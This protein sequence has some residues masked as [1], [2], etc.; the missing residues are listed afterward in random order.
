MS[1]F[2]VRGVPKS[3]QNDA[4][5]LSESSSNEGPPKISGT[6]PSAGKCAIRPE[7][8]VALIAF[9]LL[10][11]KLF[12]Q[13]STGISLAIYGVALGLF[14]WL[15]SKRRFVGREGI[16]GVC[17]LGVA[18]LPVIEQVQTLSIL[19]LVLGMTAFTVWTVLSNETNVQR[20]LRGMARFVLIFPS[21]SLRDLYGTSKEFSR[22]QDVGRIWREQKSAW[23]LP[24]IVGLVF[25]GLLV[26]ANPVMQSWVDAIFAIPWKPTTTL[27]RLLFWLLVSAGVWP[28]LAVRRLHSRL[29]AP[30]PAQ[31]QSLFAPHF[32]GVNPTSIANSLVVF[33][34]I[35]AV[36]TGLDIMYLWSGL[37]LPEGVSHAAYAH[38]GAYPLVATALLAGVF[39]MI[40]RPFTEGNDFLRTLLILW[41]L[42]NVV[43]VLSSLYRLDLYV[44]SFGLTYLRVAAGIWMALVASGLALTGWQVWH[45]ASNGWL[46]RKNATLLV[47]VLFACCFVN[48]PHVI[49]ATNLAQTDSGQQY[50]SLDMHYLCGLGPSAAGAIQAYNIENNR[51]LCGVSVFNQGLYNEGW[52]DW[53][54]RSWRVRGYLAANVR[55]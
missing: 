49:A 28:F 34:I 2:E 36:Q 47:S 9:V 23:G 42:Q 21:F 39:A 45:G 1:G 53:G 24:V 12:W 29:S 46:L 44:T 11:D 10:A 4:W 48:F 50:Q 13:H 35:F 25:S 8:L 55:R 17:M 6:E 16:A 54:F 3:L 37:D 22:G 27:G 52:R 26:A 14:I 20:V 32:S 31:V 19:F 51:A 41:I 18:I 30:V 15:T 7:P 40:S 38:R 33:N 43:L 5:W